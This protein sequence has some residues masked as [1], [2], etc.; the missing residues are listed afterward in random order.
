MFGY[1]ITGNTLV[2][3]YG[4]NPDLNV[5]STVQHIG[6]G[7]VS[8]QS[9]VETVTLP[10]SVTTIGH[11]AFSCCSKLHTI[12]LSEN[13]TSIGA[14]AFAW[15][16]S[17]TKITFPK[18]LKEIG[19]YAFSNTGLE[20]ISIPIGVTKI[21]CG[22]FVD[23]EHTLKTV[24]VGPEVTEIGKDAFGTKR[25]TT[26]Y[27]CHGSAAERYA[28][29]HRMEI[30]YLDD[31]DIDDDEDETEED[32]KK[33]KD[34]K[35]EPVTRTDAAS[36]FKIDGTTLKCYWG[37]DAQV[38]I[39][40]GVTCIAARAFRGKRF[41]THVH[42]PASLTSIQEYAFASCTRLENIQFPEGLQ[43]IGKRAFHNCRL[44]TVTL[45]ASLRI[46]EDQAFAFCDYLHTA[47]LPDTK[48]VLDPSTFLGCRH[49]E[50][51]YIPASVYVDCKNPYLSTYR[52]TII[53]CAANS[54]A[55]HF[56]LRNDISYDTTLGPALPITG[57][58]I[59]GTVLMGYTG[60][61][62]IVL[63]PDGVTAIADEVFK[64]NQTILKVYCPDSVTS[65]GVRAF[66]NCRQLR[67]VTLSKNITTIPR[68][69]FDGCSNLQTIVLPSQLTSIE[70]GAFRG[71]RLQCVTLPTSVR[72][73][74]EY[75]FACSYFLKEVHL[76]ANVTNMDPTAFRACQD[77]TIY[78]P[79]GSYA[80]HYATQHGIPTAD[81]S[82]SVA[83][84]TTKPPA[85]TALP[86]HLPRTCYDR[87]TDSQKND[88]V[89]VLNALYRMKKIPSQDYDDQV[90][91][92]I[93]YDYPDLFWVS[94]SSFRAPH[95]WITPEEK[96]RRQQAI[97]RVVNPFL[98]SVPPHLSDYEK[99]K[100]ALDW[101][102]RHVAYDREGLAEE[103]KHG[104][105]SPDDMRTIYGA[106]CL[107]K[108]VCAGYAVAMQYLCQ[109]LGVESVYRVGGDDKDRHA[110]TMVKLDDEYYHI[111][112]TW[113]DGNNNDGSYPFFCTTD[114]DMLTIWPIVEDITRM[115]V[116]R[117]VKHNY[118]AKNG[119][120]F[121]EFHQQ[122]WLAA[123]RRVLEKGERRLLHFRSDIASYDEVS[124]FCRSKELKDLLR[125]FGITATPHLDYI[126]MGVF[127]IE[128]FH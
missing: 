89:T 8:S 112:A 78:A 65:L 4:F 66:L 113:N 111:D 27:T 123:L 105:K 47:R 57:F 106:F 10:D 115:P 85:S 99:T 36:N 64:D 119:L 13:L 33:T 71:N 79:T 34:K 28:Q 24:I 108:V 29:T 43:F 35:A 23:T 9:H 117:S 91:E 7:A 110:W 63:I 21:G 103:E 74:G 87:L 96:E 95:Y 30:V 102:T 15:C 94:F 67:C 72:S 100:R 97:D 50:H 59:R 60:T 40:E 76:T 12:R 124:D 49:L 80:R 98:Q 53:H 3:Y 90:H 101:L 88:Y 17:L 77:L 83:S 86:G 54:T 128:L 26:I 18:S 56:A 52:R 116:A 109:R 92:A 32:D 62:P 114:A 1:R 42:L 107:R 41:I 45:P 70:Y 122:K 16:G 55:H 2:K 20:V 19:D 93:Q 37:R 31:I 25:N 75:A 126:R 73:I 120:F 118:Y 121:E 51:L 82:A 44:T 46:L 69:A 104:V 81:T 84:S 6:K 125:E 48:F 127:E 58:D 11:G 61:A 39:P 14:H 22:A 5:P 68:L 38:H